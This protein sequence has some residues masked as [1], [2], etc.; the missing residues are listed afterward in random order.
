MINMI[1]F[2]IDKNFDNKKKNRVS[3]K[4]NVVV[5]KEKKI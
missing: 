4:K 2:R 5:V 3:V 1:N